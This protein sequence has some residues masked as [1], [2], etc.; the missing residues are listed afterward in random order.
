MII[1]DDPSVSGR[2]AQLELA[3]ETYRLKDLDSTNG[4]RVNGIPITETFLRFD[5]RI[6]F[7]AVEGRFEPDT[8]GSQPLP[9]VEQI[10][11]KGAQTSMAP[12]DFGNA[13]PFPRRIQARDPV[14]TAILGAAILTL[15]MFIG[16]MIAVL[17]MHAPPL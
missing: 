12:V 8:R 4:T 17:A 3:G 13:S 2:H 5:D 11:A 1:I 10:E 6:R 7:G 16:S 15:L 9:P 14:R